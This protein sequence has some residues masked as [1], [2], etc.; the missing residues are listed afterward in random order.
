MLLSLNVNVFWQMQKIVD[1]KQTHWNDDQYTYEQN[2]DIDMDMSITGMAYLP[3]T[4][5]THKI[6]LDSFLENVNNFTN[7]PKMPVGVK[8]QLLCEQLLFSSAL[9]T[10][11]PVHHPIWPVREC[12]AMASVIF[13]RLFSS[14]QTLTSVNLIYVSTPALAATWSGDTCA[15]ASP[16]GWARNVTSVS[17]QKAPKHLACV[18][19]RNIFS[20]KWEKEFLPEL[21]FLNF[22]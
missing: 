11:C 10:A 17:V 20:L 19:E 16:G 15:T 2:A 4:Q 14:L 3:Q 18:Y 1:S 7:P 13:K 12:T 8:R 6:D 22:V 5:A 9:N 21:D